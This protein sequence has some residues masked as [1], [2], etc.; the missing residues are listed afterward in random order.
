MSISDRFSRRQFLHSGTSVAGGAI[1]HRWASPLLAA[2]QAPASRADGIAQA[3]KMRAAT[4][5]QPIASQ[6][7]TDAVTL[8]SGPG[9]NVLVLHGADGKLLV[10]GFVR[11]A[12]PALEKILATLG[13]GS[14][15][16][17]IDTHWHFDHADNN[18]SARAAGA[19]ILA[20][21]TT[22]QRL[23]ESH[24]LVGAHF[25]ATPS[26][27]LPTKTFAVTQKVSLN[28]EGLAL[29]VVPPA[30]TDTDVFVHFTKANVLHMGDVYFNGVY[31]FI[32][33][34]TGGNIDGMIAGADRGLKIADAST[35]IV[36]GHGPAERSR[37]ADEASRCADRR[38]GSR[39][40][41][42]AERAQRRRGAEG[43]AYG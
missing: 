33:A 1:L 4:G 20:A 32:D 22:K 38:A 25:P 14:L 18:A 11:P 10:D 41:A 36:P 8:L 43:S 17:M 16:G 23:S 34:S 40:E 37:R 15:T 7:L 21:E 31:P 35:R 3:E 12:W 2:S 24:D 9:G 13:S 26:I 27:G 6:K 19:T 42:E 28:G 5:A 30:H 29:E 39:Q